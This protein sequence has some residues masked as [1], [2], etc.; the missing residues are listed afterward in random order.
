MGLNKSLDR[1]EKVIRE[2]L[3]E[4][5]EEL[6]VSSLHELE[7]AVARARDLE[8]RLGELQIRRRENNERLGELTQPSEEHWQI[9]ER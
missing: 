2:E 3:E 9:S 7:V 1:E 5:Y 6:G 8:Q 4:V